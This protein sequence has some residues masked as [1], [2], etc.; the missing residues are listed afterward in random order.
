M[1]YDGRFSK[2]TVED[3]DTKA[4]EEFEGEEEVG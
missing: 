3:D 4:F 1:Q 2:E